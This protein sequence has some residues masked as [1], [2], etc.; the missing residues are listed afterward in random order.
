[1]AI[2]NRSAMDSFFEEVQKVSFFGRLFSW[3]R[4]RKLSYEASNEYALLRS[5]RDGVDQQI[6]GLNQLLDSARRESDNN[7]KEAARLGSELTGARTS[8]EEVRNQLNERVTRVREL[9][10]SSQANVQQIAELRAQAAALQR[11]AEERS[12]EITSYEGRLAEAVTAKDKNAERIRGLEDE[13]S[14]STSKLEELNRSLA[15][16]DKRITQFESAE[17]ARQEEHAKKMGETGHFMCALKED[18]ARLDKEREEAITAQFEEMKRTWLNHERRVEEALRA[19]C[20][21]HAIEYLGKESVPFRGKPDNTLKICEELVIFDAKSPQGDDLTNFPDYIKKQSSEVQKYTKEKSVK[22]DVYLVVPTNTIH[23]FDEH[24]MDHGDYKV[25]IVTVDSLEPIVLSLKKIEEYEFVDQLSPEERDDICR[26]I[27]RFS[28][29]T[30]RRIQVDAFFCSEGFKA[31][32][33]CDCLP[34][35]MAEKMVE[36]EKA[37][38]LNPTGEQRRKLISEKVLQKAEEEMR[39]DSDFLGLD[40]SEEVCG[41]I[42]AMPLMKEKRAER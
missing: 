2:T 15:E 16:R 30:K 33:E 1:M 31:L 32:K 10:T 14:R 20:L 7:T 38:L 34:E 28:H 26:V 25:F 4:I 36:Y 41:S 11:Q 13:L 22:K 8:L 24:T 21:K 37:T 6:A 9:E 12:A 27:G 17:A 42:A 35:D 23:L 18:K 39:K 5:Q 3:G 29:L 19:L 40:T